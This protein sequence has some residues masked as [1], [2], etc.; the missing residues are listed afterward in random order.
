[1]AARLHFQG[2]VRYR[3]R[4]AATLFQSVLEASAARVFRRNRSHGWTWYAEITARVLKRQLATAF[5]MGDVK[6]ARRYL[7]SFSIDPPLPPVDVRRVVRPQFCG[8]W[9]TPA[10]AQSGTTLLYLHGGG[11]SF[12]P[13]AY[14]GFI[15]LIALAAKAST[16]ALEYRLAPEHRFPAQLEDALPAY[17]WLL[18]T[19]THPDSL[20][21]AGDSA[22]ANLAVALLLTVRDERTPL[23]AL[24]ILLSPPTGFEG[25]GDGT[26]ACVDWITPRMLKE[27]ITWFCD[28]SQFQ[29]PLVSPILADLKGLPPMYI[30]AGSAEILFPSIRAFVD[31]ARS[32]SVDVVFET[33]ENMTHVFQLLGPGAPQ[34]AEALRRVGEVIEER[35]QAPKTKNPA[36]SGSTT[37]T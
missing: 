25:V 31:R 16:F 27:W 36:P 26:T 33:W 1:M 21:V 19:G 2:P 14:T 28:S 37:G 8:S 15:K 10:T 24:A 13:R 32:E 20:V 7:D 29:N 18:D 5:D 12:Y 17:H 35:I 4:S 9:F 34:S 11:Y 6:V 30:Q 22:G 3:L 23:P